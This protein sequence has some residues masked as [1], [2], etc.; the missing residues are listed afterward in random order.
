M[1]K[2]DFFLCENKGAD[3]LC[4]NLVFATWIE[5]VEISSFYPSFVAA[6]TGMFQIWSETLKTGFLESRFNYFTTI[7]IH[8]MKRISKQ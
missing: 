2:P 1:R 5:P 7:S 4:S 3:Q 8:I 6:Q